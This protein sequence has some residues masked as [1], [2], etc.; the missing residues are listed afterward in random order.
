[1][2][3]AAFALIFTLIA[4]VGEAAPDNTTPDQPRQR[5][6]YLSD[7][8][9]I[10]VESRIYY[11]SD[12]YTPRRRSPSEKEEY[13][14]SNNNAA[15]EE[16]PCD[17][18]FF[19][20]LF[21]DSGSDTDE[22]EVRYRPGRIYYD[23]IEDDF[24]PMFLTGLGGYYKSPT[25]EIRGAYLTNRLSFQ[26]DDTHDLRADDGL[27]ADVI[28]GRITY[29]TGNRAFSTIIQAARFDGVIEYNFFDR[30][31]PMHGQKVIR[32]WNSSW[33]KQ[34]I[35]IE[36]INRYS[37]RNNH[38]S[39]YGF[40][41]SYARHKIPV[42]LNF[43]HRNGEE[44]KWVKVKMAHI[45]RFMAEID[46]HF[47]FETYRRMKNAAYL[48]FDWMGGLGISSLN[49]R[50]D[51][52]FLGWNFSTSSR[53]SYAIAHGPLTFELGGNMSVWYEK[54]GGGGKIYRDEEDGEEISRGTRIFV[55]EFT[56]GPFVNLTY[57]F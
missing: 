13:S 57:S 35:F 33:Y 46:M 31:S 34:G 32:D 47:S 36:R 52:S 42:S 43:F 3:I 41:L 8:F 25:W 2:K 49:I 24:A 5:R 30:T 29:S 15:Y 17:G 22:D 23:I 19:Y 21:T 44:P 50:D 38:E 18:G 53:I 51:D 39:R 45:N 10:S 12:M 48:N 40:G 14:S 26:R 11:W 54:F 37:S 7:G 56:G 27:L 16:E 4:S 6:G 20:C 1:M 9:H 28:D 55:K